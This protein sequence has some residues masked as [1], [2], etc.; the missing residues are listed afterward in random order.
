MET[1]NSIKNNYI[2]LITGAGIFSIFLLVPLIFSA[3]NQ[4]AIFYAI[5]QEVELREPLIKG[6]PS[7]IVVFKG[8]Q[9][10]YVANRF[11]LYRYEKPAGGEPVWNSDTPP[12]V[13][14]GGEILGVAATD[15]VL[16]VLTGEGLKRWD[17]AALTWEPVPIDSGE[18]ADQKGY[19]DLQTVYAD[20][21]FLFVGAGNS[22]PTANSDNYAIRYLHEDTATNPPTFT[23]KI[24]KSGV[25][26]L[27]GAVF[28]GT[29]H[30]VATRGSGI[31]V[32]DGSSRTL[33]GEPIPNSGKQDDKKR[34][35]MGMIYLKDS[36]NTVAAVDRSGEILTVTGTGFTPHKNKIGNY[37]TGALALW[38][39]PPPPDTSFNPG[40]PG[41]PDETPPRLLLVGIQG[42]LT[43]TTQTYN[44]GY[45][46]I[47]LDESGSLPADLSINVPG[48][49]S[50][51][52]ISNSDKYT[53]SLGKL[54]IDY[55]FQ[56]PYALNPAM[57]IF[58]STHGKEGL[59]SYKD[60]GDG[61]MTWNAE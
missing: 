5:S 42:S 45:R 34:H 22:L 53:T 31:F 51:P 58:A 33:S 21:G 19:S 23:L 17:S 29:N 46:E 48:K 28:N 60:H 41:Y 61:D 6:T 37:T 9:Y 3:C 1:M 24:L 14:P 7:N 12:L 13:Q 36:Q 32:F 18:T 50:T 30:F 20:S 11:S 38:R 27:S 40:D 57:P 15:T 2:R 39:S 44:N 10:L 4:D 47:E 55:L 26:L 56:V 49:S 25:H 54:P 16:C 8:D 35:I 52:S 43:S 59:W